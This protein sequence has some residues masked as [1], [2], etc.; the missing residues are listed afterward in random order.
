MNVLLSI[1]P[2]YVEKI[3]AGTK[4]YE[5]RKLGFRSIEN[6]EKVFIYSSSPVKRIIG[7]FKTNKI[8]E[9]QPIKLW[10]QCKEGA[11]IEEKDFFSYFNNKEKGLAIFVED[12]ELFKKP[13]DPKEIKEDFIPPQS[14]CYIEEDFI[15]KM[16]ELS[17]EDMYN[18]GYSIRMYRILEDDLI[19]FLNYI[20]AEYY[21]YDERKKIYSP[22]LSDLIIRIGSQIEMFFRNW[23]LI[24]EL[25]HKTVT[26]ELKFANYKRIE[27]DEKR[28]VSLK[29]KKVVFLPTE[30][31]TTPFENWNKWKKDDNNWWNAY[32]NVKHNGFKF[33]EEGNLQNIIES[34]AALFLLNCLHEKVK[35]KLIEYKYIEINSAS[36]EQINMKTNLDLKGYHVESKLFEYK[37]LFPEITGVDDC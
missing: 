5:F 34:L 2:Q 3:K 11:G 23:D 21:N 4:K 29:D 33:K 8:V 15:T 20:P 27:S 14:F 12:L 24:Q 36:R 22:V 18:S 35:F 16:R 17:S 13:V 28:R 7:S 1:K 9:D 32:N 37:Y 26:R 6:S 31:A 19:D 10:E 30:E 25:N